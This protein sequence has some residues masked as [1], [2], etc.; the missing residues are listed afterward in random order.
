[1]RNLLRYYANNFLQYMAVVV[2][3]VALVILGSRYT[4]LSLFES[5]SYMMPSLG[6]WLAPL[7]MAGCRA[8]TSLP[9]YFGVRRRNTFIGIQ[10][11]AV[12]MV[13]CTL[14]LAAVGMGCIKMW[15]TDY[16][17]D[18]GPEGFPVLLAASLAMTELAL[19]AQYV[20][21]GGKQR[22]ASIMLVL[23]MI[24]FAASITLGVIKAVGFPIPLFPVSV[25]RP[26]WAVFTAVCA[27]ATLAGGALTWH[28]YRKA[29]IRL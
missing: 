24:V 16:S 22:T 1:M 17:V 3:F 11:M 7:T 20:P 8:T 28:Y 10:I 15:T 21:N 12:A 4:P 27:L 29:V 13:L 6:L 5:Y 23:I 18:L 25:L 19:L 2:V 9:I 26:G 14:A